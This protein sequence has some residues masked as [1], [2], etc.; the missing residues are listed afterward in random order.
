MQTPKQCIKGSKPPPTPPRKRSH[1]GLHQLKQVE[2]KL[3]N[4][5]EI[6][7]LTSYLLTSPPVAVKSYPPV[8]VASRK[9]VSQVLEYIRLFM[10][11]PIQGL[12]HPT[13]PL[14]SPLA[15]VD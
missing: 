3:V 10:G 7:G 6:S 14:S 12:E 2:N 13:K 4:V 15:E 8:S 9:T 1:W 5:G 11:P